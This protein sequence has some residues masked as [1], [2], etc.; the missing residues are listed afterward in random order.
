MVVA[1]TGAAATALVDEPA[2]PL[3]LVL[4]PRLVALSRRLW[5]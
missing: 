2:Q 4:W 5:L 1:L 3:D